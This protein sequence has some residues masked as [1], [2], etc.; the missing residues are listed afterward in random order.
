VEPAIGLDLA[1]KLA[2]RPSGIAERKQRL[3]GPAALGD[4]AQ[5]VDGGGEAHAFVDGQR[6][7]GFEIVGAVQDETA[8]GLHWSAEMHRHGAKPNRRPD[9]LLWRHDVELLQ[10][11]REA[12]IGRAL[13]DDDAHGAVG[14]VGA[15]IDHGAGKTRIAHRRHGHEQAA[16]EIAV[17]LTLRWCGTRH[18]T[19]LQAS[20]A[21]WEGA[22]VE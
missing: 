14:G 15:H 16:V 18:D 2:R 21:H 3:V 19:R 12:D 10:E 13:I 17:T 20:S 1:F 7:L 4:I 8:P 22:M 5:D 9:A 6:A 11:L